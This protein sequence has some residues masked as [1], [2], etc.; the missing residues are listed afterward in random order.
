MIPVVE[1]K[2]EPFKGMKNIGKVVAEVTYMPAYETIRGGY[3]VAGP[4]ATEGNFT[5]RILDVMTASLDSTKLGGMFSNLA[6][7]AKLIDWH[8]NLVKQEWGSLVTDPMTFQP[9][10]SKLR[11]FQTIRFI[12]KISSSLSETMKMLG[13]KELC[14]VTDNAQYKDLVKLA[15]NRAAT[16]WDRKFVQGLVKRIA[17]GSADGDFVS[18]NDVRTHAY[19][20]K[21]ELKGRLKSW[22]D[23]Y[24]LDLENVFKPTDFDQKD[25]VV[26]ATVLK[27]K[28][29]SI[30]AFWE[31]YCIPGLY[32]TKRHFIHWSFSNPQ[33]NKKP[34]PHWS[35]TLA[36]KGAGVRWQ[37]DYSSNEARLQ[38]EVGTTYSRLKQYF[39]KAPE[40]PAMEGLPYR[41]KWEQLDEHL[42]SVAPIRLETGL[43][44]V[45]E[46][47]LPPVV[48]F[49]RVPPI[50]E[51]PATAIEHLLKEFG[52]TVTGKKGAAHKAFCK[53]LSDLY[54]EFEVQVS[55][56]IVD[57][58]MVRVTPETI[59][60]PAPIQNRLFPGNPYELVTNYLM[61][62][63]LCRHMRGKAILEAEY[64]SDLYTPKGIFGDL[65]RSGYPP[66]DASFASHRNRDK[67][68][69]PVPP[70][71]LAF[72]CPF[73][74]P[75]PVS[76]TD[77]RPDQREKAIEEEDEQRMEQDLE[78]EGVDDLLKDLI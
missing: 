74:M 75:D 19:A 60:N 40:L 36:V 51:V 76:S 5:P 7:E 43:K 26:I 3:Y 35:A 50:S 10:R 31:T 17:R 25:D 39:K 32:D 52:R 44:V 70:E 12:R 59:V 77:W 33:Q 72:V 8:S 15:L 11:H 16:S 54:E 13:D 58:P 47:E 30:N 56:A 53:L 37:L 64:T 4:L 49:N 48:V 23:F 24:A 41:M 18:W 21:P 67:R 65:T 73:G 63:Y 28:L 71:F 68:G 6:G 9:D 1:V 42:Y 46:T 29:I 20:L 66:A 14:A 2:F 69:N 55:A 78:V 61:A 57:K 45:C 62:F 38:P 27:D 34:M 22:D